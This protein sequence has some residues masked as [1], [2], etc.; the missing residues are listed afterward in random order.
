MKSDRM[1]INTRS[2]SSGDGIDGIFFNFINN[3][4]IYT[5]IIERSTTSDEGTNRERR[6]KNGKED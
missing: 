5:K 1:D 6:N 3:N 4:S 2:T